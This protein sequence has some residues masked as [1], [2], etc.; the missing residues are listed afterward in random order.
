MWIFFLVPMIVI[1]I[2]M[3]GTKKIPQFPM[4][5]LWKFFL[6]TDTRTGS[7]VTDDYRSCIRADNTTGK[8]PSST[9]GENERQ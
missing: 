8:Q 2:I 1:N 3:M 5:F 4:W 6:R 7:I 9:C